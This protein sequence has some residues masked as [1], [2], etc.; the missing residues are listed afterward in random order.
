MFAL[1][2]LHASIPLHIITFTL[3]HFH[4]FTLLLFHNFTLLLFH[5]FTLSLILTF[6]AGEPVGEKYR[7]IRC[8]RIKKVFSVDETRLQ[9]NVRC[10]IIIRPSIA[11]PIFCPVGCTVIWQGVFIQFPAKQNW[12]AYLWSEMSPQTSKTKTNQ[13]KPSKLDQADEMKP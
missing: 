3:S 12:S 9:Q 13:T 4:S 8:Q 7:F 1:S 5:T 6:T 10:L 2:L 11:L